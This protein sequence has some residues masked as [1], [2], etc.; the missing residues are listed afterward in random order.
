LKEDSGVTDPER[1]NLS[2]PHSVCIIG[3]D[4]VG[5]PLAVEAAAAGFDVTGYDLDPD[6]VDRI[7]KRRSPVPEFADPRLPA[8]VERGLLRGTCNPGVL[9][10][11]DIAIVC[12]PTPLD[13]TRDPDVSLVVQGLDD[14]RR[15]LHPGQLILIESTTYP[16]FT[17][18]VV[19]P[20]L[21]RAGMAVGKDFHLAFSPERIDPGNQAYGLRN[22]P[23]VVGGVTPA[24]TER[25]AAF[26]RCVVDRVHLVSSPDAAEMAKLLENTFRSVNIGLANE[27]ALMC[28][29]LRLDT[30][31]V[32]AAAATKPF[33]FM[34][35]FPGP[36]LGGH[37][38]PIDP[39]YLSWKLKTLNYS[40]KFIELADALNSSMP[41]FVVARVQDL[42]NRHSMCLSGR[43]ILV[44][45]VAYKRDVS[46]TRE[47]PAHRVIELLLQ[48]GANVSYHDPHV[49]A[50][51]VGTAAMQSAPPDSP[52]DLALIVT[53]HAG[54]DY[55]ALCRTQP[56]V[57][58]TRGI[59]RR[60]GLSA[61]HIHTL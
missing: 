12:V 11:S 26:Y 54:I 33:G 18:E 2:G 29:H 44:V 27:V 46:D 55:Q 17:T 4:Y 30:W 59:T 42:L 53:D 50:F 15:Y 3:M 10:S 39:L 20:M 58:D 47:T 6:K 60:L 24:C 43:R 36:G 45:G 19:L 34:P 40:V 25:A 21:E 22:T 51:A 41:E 32:I 48:K 56:L 5:L 23:K 38:I 7:N 1:D 13:K 61:P 49:P 16:G 14:I 28:N 52:A 8:L 35:F 31:E 57:F 37:C 9:L